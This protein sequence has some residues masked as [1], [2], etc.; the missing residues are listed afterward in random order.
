[1]VEVRKEEM[2]QIHTGDINKLL[3]LKYL[4]NLKKYKLTAHNYE[5]YDMYKNT[6]E[7]PFR[8]AFSKKSPMYKKLG[9]L[10]GP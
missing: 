1:M 6:F 7:E 2:I 9:A 8:I 3:A 10:R 4:L 5:D